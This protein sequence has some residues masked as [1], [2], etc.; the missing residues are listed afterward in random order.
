M[1]ASGEKENVCIS[2]IYKLMLPEMEDLRISLGYRT[3][4]TAVPQ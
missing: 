2:L 4:V 3:K 1:T